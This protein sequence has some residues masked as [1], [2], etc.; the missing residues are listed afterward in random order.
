MIIRLGKATD[1][2]VVADHPHV[3]RH[4]ARLTRDQEG[5]LLLEDLG[6]TNG[7]FVNDA[8]VL[9]KYVVPTDRVRL[10]DASE[11]LVSEILKYNN[12]YSAEFELLKRVYDDYVDA[13]VKIQSANQFK[14]RL[15]QS[16]P[17]AIPGIVGVIV[18]FLGKGSMTWFSV[19]LLITVCAP[20]IGIYLGA[21]QSARTP[22]QLQAL[23]NQF[24]IDYVCPKC[25]TFLGEVPWESLRNRKQCPACKAKWVSE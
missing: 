11:W 20:M 14:T 6:S 7:T 18:G 23:A 24:K 4:H 15:L 22:A 16:L 9:R 8:Q 19:S 5:R 17:F 12:D 13:K 1:N 25:G 2:E 10:G 3:S 21:K